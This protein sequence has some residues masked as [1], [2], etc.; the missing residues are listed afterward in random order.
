M[1]REGKKGHAPNREEERN[2]EGEREIRREGG[3][4]KRG[5]VEGTSR[6]AEGKGRPLKMA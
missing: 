5:R 6:S 2:K 1:K 4:R 3:A